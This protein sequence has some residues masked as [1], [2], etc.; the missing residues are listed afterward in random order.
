MVKDTSDIGLDKHKN[1][2]NVSD[3]ISRKG[4]IIS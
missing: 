1:M 4:W 2:I 3:Q